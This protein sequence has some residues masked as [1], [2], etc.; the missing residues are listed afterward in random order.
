M[1]V[2]AS[3]FDDPARQ[4]F[5]DSAEDH[6][7]ALDWLLGQ[8][9]Q[10]SFATAP[11]IAALRQIAHNLKGLG[12]AF[13]ATGLAA[14][15]HWLED[16]LSGLERLAGD[17]L[18]AV[19]LIADRFQDAVEAALSGRDD[20]AVLLAGL[21]RRAAASNA[22]RVLL[23]MPRVRA[24]QIVGHLQTV[25]LS[26]DI[27]PTAIEALR[28]AS[29][30]R[31]GLIILAAVLPEL[32]GIDLACALAAMPATGAIPLALLTSLEREDA[33]L[34]ELPERVALLTPGPGFGDALDRLLAD[35]GLV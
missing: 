6:L 31:P 1:G 27:V 17:D 10:V 23:V 19:Q 35:A 15:A 8:V 16:Y 29:R 21:P 18:A 13:G 4:E 30:K 5:E 11:Q 3:G 14:L 2:A 20:P 24:R 34:G 22:R 28:V 12:A 33:A 7:G 26:V 32:G 25:D 9:G